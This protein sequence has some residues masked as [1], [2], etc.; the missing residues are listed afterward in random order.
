MTQSKPSSSLSNTPESVEPIEPIESVE[1]HR[2]EISRLARN[3]DIRPWPMSPRRPLLFSSSF[4]LVYVRQS[5]VVLS[6]RSEA[7][8][9]MF[10]EP[11]QPGVHAGYFS[12][13][14]SASVQPCLM[15]S[16]ES[17]PVPTPQGIVF[18]GEHELWELWG[19]WQCRGNRCD[20]ATLPRFRESV[21]V[22]QW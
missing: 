11:D 10:M 12:A 20:S 3:R 4:S 14:S 22:T 7:V 19:L 1:P 6:V 9:V 8:V 13:S 21:V 18:R 5:I 17:P 15:P 2:S 16:P